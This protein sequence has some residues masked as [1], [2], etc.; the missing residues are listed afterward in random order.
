MTA[1]RE[2]GTGRFRYFALL[3]V[4]VALTGAAQ[5]D[6]RGTIRSYRTAHEREIVREYIELLS[7]PN[8]AS[9]TP[10]IRNTRRTSRRC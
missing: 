6:L 9:D 1:C 5:T 2:R 4:S 10:N 3:M 7:I 8:L